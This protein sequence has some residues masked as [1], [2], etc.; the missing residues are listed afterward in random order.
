MAA[1][2]WFICVLLLCS[3]SARASSASMMIF[4]PNLRDGSI[5]FSA[6]FDAIS[7]R[8][9]ATEEASKSGKPIDKVF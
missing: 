4:S 8:Q 7:R 1:V 9:T 5:D 2:G 3:A 6:L